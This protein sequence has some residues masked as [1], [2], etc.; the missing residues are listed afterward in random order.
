MNSELLFVTLWLRS[1]CY[2]FDFVVKI[3]MNSIYYDVLRVNKK[4]LVN[5]KR[6]SINTAKAHFETFSSFTPF[7]SPPWI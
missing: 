5:S 7:I 4:K 2:S 3:E 1:C 6:I